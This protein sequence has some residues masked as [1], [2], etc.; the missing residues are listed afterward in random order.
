MIQFYLIF[1]VFLVSPGLIFATEIGQG[2]GF[3]DFPLEV[4]TD[5]LGQSRWVLL[6]P[7]TEAQ[8]HIDASDAR[9]ILYEVA[10]DLLTGRLSRAVQNST[11][12]DFSQVF[13]G[14]AHAFTKALDRKRIQL[15]VGRVTLTPF[16][17]V[18]EGVERGAQA[19]LKVPITF[20]IIGTPVTSLHLMLAIGTPHAASYDSTTLGPL[21]AL[22]QTNGPDQAPLTTV[23]AKTVVSILHSVHLTPDDMQQLTPQVVQI[24]RD[25]LSRATSQGL[26]FGQPAPRFTKPDATLDTRFRFPGTAHVTLF[27]EESKTQTFSHDLTLGFLSVVRQIVIQHPNDAYRRSADEYLQDIQAMLPQVWTAEFDETLRQRLSH[28]KQRWPQRRLQQGRYT[29]RPE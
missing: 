22:V 26:A 16:M 14:F 8:V 25:A 7:A 15:A 17:A 1:M 13:H 5:V 18:G 21:Q 28:G 4:D 2:K 10:N 19:T 9:T 24:A 11:A 27:I 23:E 12:V 29:I 6:P 20:S 3:I